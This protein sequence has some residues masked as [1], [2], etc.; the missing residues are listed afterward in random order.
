MQNDSHHSQKFKKTPLILSI[1]FLAF[2]CFAFFFLYKEINNNKKIAQETQ[3]KWQDE[4][5]RRDG[6]RSLE[7][8]VKSITKEKDLLESHFAQSSNIVPFLD[9]IEKL[10]VSSKTKSEVVSVDISQDGSGLLVGL[11]AS[12]NFEAIYKFL[13][14]LENSPYELEFIS[15]NIQKLSAQAGWEATFKIKLL[16]FI[17]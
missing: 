12:G 8:L 9:T 11:K 6:I 1:M 13:T 15:V 10:A 2:S 16:S 7:R 14:L 17:Q 3:T 4:A 5:N